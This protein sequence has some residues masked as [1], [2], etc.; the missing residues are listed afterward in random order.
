MNL[1]VKRKDGV[2]LELDVDLFLSSVETIVRDG[3]IITPTE[4]VG[5]IYTKTASVYVR[6]EEDKLLEAI[7]NIHSKGV[8][9]IEVEDFIL[10]NECKSSWDGF[11]KRMTIKSNSRLD[12]AISDMSGLGGS[13]IQ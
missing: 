5:V 1:K 3:T 4:N 13:V 8:A 12:M 6:V 9:A 10:A 7:N 11:F 2:H